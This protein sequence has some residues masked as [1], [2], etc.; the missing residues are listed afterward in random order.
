MN[1]VNFLYVLSGGITGLL[2]GL[3]GVGGGA[4]MTPLLISIFGVNP[5]VAVG[6][7]LLFSAI[8]KIVAAGMHWDKKNIDWQIVNRLWVGSLPAAAGM[9]LFTSNFHADD[10]FLNA[11]RVTVAVVV[12]FTS[13]AM[14]FQDTIHDVGL[15]LRVDKG[16]MFKKFQPVLTVIF[17][18]M[19][20]VI[21]SLTS[22]GSGA[23]GA[24]VLLYLYP[25]R[26]TSGKLIGTD[27]V[28]AI[29]LALISGLGYSASDGVD[30]ELLV[31]L[32]IGSLPAVIAGVFLS[33][34]VNQKFLKKILAAV[35][36][37]IGVKLM[38]N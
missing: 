10:G 4:L 6:T 22:I 26:L 8:T 25:I 21:V 36:F 35:L 7:D 3:T 38:L 2:V 33:R 32:L 20:G 12:I 27:V 9:I 15:K 19:I 28:H 30:Y 17:G 23:L 14:I 16:W 13:V 24:V 18:A 31:N 11:M 34:Y 1:D 29:P 5:K 37:L